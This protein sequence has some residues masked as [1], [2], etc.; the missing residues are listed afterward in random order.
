MLLELVTELGV[1]KRICNFVSRF[2]N[3]LSNS[4]TVDG[5]FVASLGSAPCDAILFISVRLAIF[6]I[7]ILERLKIVHGDNKDEQK[8]ELD[9]G[10]MIEWVVLRDGLEPLNSNAGQRRSENRR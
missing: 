1:P 5:K 2:G 9:G 7:T 6:K 10:L 4:E 3:I 8:T